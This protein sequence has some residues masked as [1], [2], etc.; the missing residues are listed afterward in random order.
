MKYLNQIR[1]RSDFIKRWVLAGLA[2]GFLHTVLEY[3]AF[4]ATSQPV[5]FFPLLL[6]A[7][8]AVVSISSSLAMVEIFFETKFRQKPFYQIVLFRSVIFTLIISFWLMVVNGIWTGLMQGRTFLEGVGLYASSLMYAINMIVIF[9]FS[10]LLVGLIQIDNLHSR[11]E[12]VNYILGKYHWPREEKRFFCFIDLKDSTTIAEVLGH[13]QFGY[14]LKDFFSDITEAIRQSHAEI[15]QYIGDEIILCWPYREGIKDTRVISSFFLME[16]CINRQMDK[17]QAKY[18][19]SPVFKAGLQG[20]EV[21]VT[22]VGEIKKEIVY[23]GDVLNTASRIQGECNR[24][25]KRFLTSGQM[26]RLLPLPK[27]VQAEFMEE[28][29]P[30]GKKEIVRLYSLERKTAVLSTD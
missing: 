14:F 22:W 4:S 19:Y 10:I 30:K 8:F 12:L 24:L 27:E 17:Y 6:R 11:G 20:G 5:Q 2:V 21:L 26:I 29:T 16:E 23:L 25:G 9:L 3:F 7:L 18:G 1:Q 13:V 15:Y 28:F